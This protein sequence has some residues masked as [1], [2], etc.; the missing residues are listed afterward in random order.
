MHA[1][2]TA[3]FGAVALAAAIA[4]A[5]LAAGADTAYTLLIGGRPTDRAGA[6]AR[7]HDGTVY[8][9]L[10]RATRALSGLL[11]YNGAHSALIT[12][13]G[14][15]AQFTVGSKIAVMDGT[16]V[17]LKGAPFVARGDTFVP[18]DAFAILARATFATDAR[19]KTVDFVPFSGSTVSDPAA[20][21]AP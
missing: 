7:V 4:T 20:S 13:N 17:A 15:S 9:D 6:S 5:P 14:H 21:P 18:I 10:V 19:T 3:R 2:L 12:L 11:T 1:H 16:D 8:V